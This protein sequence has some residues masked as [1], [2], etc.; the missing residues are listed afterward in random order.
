[1]PGRRTS[2]T[3]DKTD[4]LRI[5][6]CIEVP[7]SIKERIDK[8]QNVLKALD[9]PVSWTRPDNV[10]LTLK[11][12]GNVKS[13]R[14]PDINAA[15]ERAARD[16]AEFQVEVAGSGCFPSARAPRVFWIGLNDSSTW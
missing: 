9:A 3:A 13:S 4:E 6:I 7:A 14:L 8:L 2:D 15:C 10:H 5:F 11:F 12:L 1:M 16:F